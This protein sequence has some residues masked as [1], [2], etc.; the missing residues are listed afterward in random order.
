[1]RSSTATTCWKPLRKVQ[2]VV[3][4]LER[5][6]PERA[7]A[8]SRRALHYG[9]LNYMGVKNILL[10]GLDPQAPSGSA[11]ARGGCPPYDY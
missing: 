10:K 5:H 11:C 7:N 2:A 6:P 1:M 8:A 3:T 4:Y 9:C